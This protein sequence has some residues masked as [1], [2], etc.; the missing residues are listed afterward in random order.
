[1]IAAAVAAGGKDAKAKAP[2]S[3]PA[4]KDAKGAIPVQEE[5]VK[6]DMMDPLP[7]VD[8]TKPLKYDLQE[9]PV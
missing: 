2:P 4:G 7:I 1:M 8:F 5:S 6:E 3:K 9:A